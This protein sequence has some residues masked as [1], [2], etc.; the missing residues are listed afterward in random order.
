M[1]TFDTMLDPAWLAQ[2]AGA[3]FGALP[4][5]PSNMQAPGMQAPGNMAP[6]G[7]PLASPAGLSAG[8]PGTPL[9]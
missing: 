3:M 4:A 9:P 1:P 5:G 6:P 8:V 7:S 2:M